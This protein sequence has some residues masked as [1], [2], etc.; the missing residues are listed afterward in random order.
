MHSSRLREIIF[1]AKS[2]SKNRLRKKMTQE[3]LK[4]AILMSV[5]LSILKGI[6][7]EEIIDLLASKSITGLI[8]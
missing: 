7:N 4:T 8:L 3:H 2:V 1:K 6:C 5:E